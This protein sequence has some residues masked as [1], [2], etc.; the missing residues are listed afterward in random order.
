MTKLTKAKHKEPTGID[1]PEIVNTIFDHAGNATLRELGVQLGVSAATVQRWMK[2]YPEIDAA[3]REM[4][5]YVDDGI[6]SAL[7]KRAKG[8]NVPYEETTT[9]DEGDKTVTTVKTGETHIPPDVGAAKF[10]LSNRRRDVW[11]DRQEIVVTGNL[12]HI[13]DHLDEI[14]DLP[15]T[16]YKDLTDGSR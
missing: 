1:V 10:W 4:R 11:S 2:E 12:K 5:S 6:E 9:K 3:V 15:A 8:Y 13:L 7:A 16:E 14:V